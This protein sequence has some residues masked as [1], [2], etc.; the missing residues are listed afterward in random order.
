ML[1]HSASV[2]K[3][4][5]AV[6]KS[7]EV[8]LF[9][10]EVLVSLRF[11]SHFLLKRNS[12]HSL[13]QETSKTIRD[14]WGNKCI[15]STDPSF[16]SNRQYQ[17]TRYVSYQMHSL[18]NNFQGRRDVCWEASDFSH[19]ISHCIIKAYRD[20]LPRLVEDMLLKGKETWLNPRKSVIAYS[21]LSLLFSLSRTWLVHLHHLH[22][23]HL[24]HRHVSFIAILSD[25]S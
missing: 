16:C 7:S 6:Q 3:D 22:H 13:S 2:V 25:D 12:W 20:T 15:P 23:N 14:E 18:Q 5:I 21:L 8:L 9:V 10:S 11:P 24:P 4:T 1:I 19:G 17:W